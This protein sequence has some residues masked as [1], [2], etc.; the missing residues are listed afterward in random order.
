MSGGVPP[1]SPAGK[2][3]LKSAVF[4]GCLGCDE[5]EAGGEIGCVGLRDCTCCCGFWGRVSTE[6]FSAGVGVGVCV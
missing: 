1:Y 4:L 3:G 2:T 6:V 5:G